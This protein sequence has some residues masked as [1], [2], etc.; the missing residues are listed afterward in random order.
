MP[1]LGRVKRIGCRV[2]MHSFLDKV[3]TS[4]SFISSVFSCYERTCFEKKK[5]TYF[6]LENIFYVFLWQLLKHCH[7][8][9][10]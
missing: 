6:G 8:V 10:F 2:N 5:K 4:Q 7:L 3:G 1:V 9:N